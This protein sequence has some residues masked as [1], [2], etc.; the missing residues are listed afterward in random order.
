MNDS[1][2]GHNESVSDFIDS[3]FRKQIQY[4]CTNMHQ[5]T[6][7][8]SL[9]DIAWWSLHVWMEPKV[10]CLT[11][12]FLFLLFSQIKIRVPAKP[13]NAFSLSCSWASCKPQLS[14]VV[15]FKA[16]Y[17]SI[18]ESKLSGRLYPKNIIYLNRPAWTHC[19]VGIQVLF[20]LCMCRVSY[21]AHVDEWTCH[22]GLQNYFGTI[23]SADTHTHTP[24]AAAVAAVVV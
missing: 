13:D 18:P 5:L 6:A 8:R 9:W 14:H 24:A 10:G 15:Y 23:R 12:C 20:S 21:Y 17:S 11:R 3:A 16:E 1:S 2:S 22:P 7:A 4:F 19:S